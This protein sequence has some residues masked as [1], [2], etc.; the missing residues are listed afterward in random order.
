MGSNHTVPQPAGTQSLF[1]VQTTPVCWW[2]SYCEV[3]T[4]SWATFFA[5]EGFFAVFLAGAFLGAVFLAAG[6]FLGAVFLTAVALLAGAFERIRG[7]LLCP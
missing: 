4:S 2:R 6:A 7:V 3:L 1:G 5:V